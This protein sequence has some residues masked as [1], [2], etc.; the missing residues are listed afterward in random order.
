MKKILII[1]DG[2]TANR[3]LQR[4]ISSDATNNK[5]YIIYYNDKTLP[6]SK[7]ERFIYYK[8]DPTS[9][10]KIKSLLDHEDFYQCMIIAANR[11]DTLE[12]YNN[13]RAVDKNIQLVMLDKW[14]LELDDS[15]LTILD[16]H[17]ILSN[18]FSNYLPDFPLYAQ[19]IGIGTGE[20]MELKIPFGSPYIYRHIRNIDQKR[21]KISAIF[22]EHKL[23][24]PNPSTMLLP[25]DSILAV[26]N[27]NVLKGVYKSIKREFGQ[28]PIPFG[29]NIY[30]YID[31]KS[32]SDSEIELLTNDAMI[33]HSK[34][35]SKKLIFKVVNA[36]FSDMLDKIKTYAS[37]SSMIVEFDYH[38]SDFETIIKDDLQ[39]CYIGLFIVNDNFLEDNIEL[40]YRLKVPIFKVSK[41]GFFTIKE[42][43]FMG[44]NSKIAEKV[45]SIIFDISSQ[46]GSEIALFDV[47]LENSQE[48]D[49]IISHFQNLAKLF[50]KRIKV[51]KTKQ[52]PILELKQRDDFLQFVVFDKS[53]LS[54]K[55]I[56]YFSTDI[57]KHYFR[58]KDNYQL[59][60]PSEL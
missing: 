45:S 58:L 26:G 41:K 33:L 36:T 25:N 13:I 48:Q 4:L 20:I 14:D 34:L 54:S 60:I 6:E 37:S 9:L 39:D 28:F 27:P 11:V 5:Y 8:F 59:F 57:Q 1:A 43:V 55:F 32:M 22:R 21:W 30:C 53:I 31:M 2:I 17:D 16:A 51:I 19:N 10:T 35:N 44:S 23:L 15:F 29:E 7:L 52:N 24:L 42:S 18:I 12:S 46:L 38:R 50:E 56:S 49:K 40:F 47:H 3:F